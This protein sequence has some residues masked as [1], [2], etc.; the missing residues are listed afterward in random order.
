MLADRVT[1]IAASASAL[2]PRSWQV[3]ANMPQRFRVIGVRRE[4]I[5]QQPFGGFAVAAL[6]E[7]RRLLQ[8]DARLRRRAH[9]CAVRRRSLPRRLRERRARTDGARRSMRHARG[10]LAPAHA[11]SMPA[12]GFTRS[13]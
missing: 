1:R 3:I 11:S 4:N 13:P 10:V 6:H 2:R 5:A 7:L 8:F 12:S 9:A